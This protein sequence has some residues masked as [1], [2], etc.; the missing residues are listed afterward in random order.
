[1][2][3]EQR[4]LETLV[5]RFGK[6]RFEMWFGLAPTILL[7]RSL[8]KISVEY[9]FAAEWIRNHFHKQIN[10]VV[11]ELLGKSVKWE[12]AVL[13][14]ATP[15]A[16]HHEKHKTEEICKRDSSFKPK[17][18]STKKLNSKPG[19]ISPPRLPV[20]H[21]HVS[22]PTSQRKKSLPD[23]SRIKKELPV[24]RS[25]QKNVP[26][27]VGAILR[28]RP[29]GEKSRNETSPLLATMENFVEG[30]SNCLAVR[31]ADM[32]IR[33]PGKISPVYVHGPTSVG[34]T[35]LLEAIKNQVRRNPRTNPPLYLTAEQFTSY[36]IEGIKQGIPLFRNK[37]KDI[38]VLL[39]DDIQFFEGKESTQIEFLRTLE[40]MKRQ[41]LQVVLSG[42]RSLEQLRC[43]LKPEI[44]TRIEAGMVC[45]IQP[46]ERETLLQVFRQMVR[47]R[48]L[49]IPEEVCRF[50]VSRMGVHAR[51]LSGALNRLHAILLTTGEPIT[52]ASAEDALGDLIRNHVRSIKLR[53]IEKVICDTFQLEQQAL[54]S[55]SRT[56]KISHP[57]MLAMWL[58]RKHTRSAFAEIGKFF[59]DRNHSTVVSAQKKVDVW[60]QENLE[61]ETSGTSLSVSEIISKV[62]NQ[63]LTG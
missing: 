28:N 32:A 14:T 6:S 2:D 22:P 56:K 55:R 18:S 57:R 52:L 30:P 44:V 11:V 39:I 24:N 15:V 45:E 8:L 21:K 38:S 43:V 27:Q 9:P 33:Y 53:D 61:M 7:E 12:I 3:I 46:P 63:L 62:E 10:D 51:Q 54:Q 34:K 49:D 1:M 20:V 17:V 4:I 37:F 13:E 23:E 47:S 25:S 31:G 60:L 16:D 5:S 41:G 42:N 26:R 59:G 40:A 19:K 58:A 29:T 36:F 50:V 35:H 48:K